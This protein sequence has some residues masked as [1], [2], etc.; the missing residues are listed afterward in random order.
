MWA[1]P[2]PTCGLPCAQACPGAMSCKCFLSGSKGGT[3]PKGPTKS[4]T[5]L[6][7]IDEEEEVRRCRLYT[8]S[9]PR[10]R[11]A[12]LPAASAGAEFW[13]KWVSRAGASM[14]DASEA[15]TTPTALLEV[16]A[17]KSH[18]PMPQMRSRMLGKPS[19]SCLD[20]EEV[21]YEARP[22]SVDSIRG[23]TPWPDCWADSPASSASPRKRSPGKTHHNRLSTASTAA[24]SSCYSPRRQSRLSRLSTSS[25][26]SMAYDEPPEPAK[27]K[28]LKTS[29]PLPVGAH[30]WNWPR[31]CD[32]KK[33]RV[34]TFD[35]QD[36]AAQRDGFVDQLSKLSD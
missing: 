36:L 32:E 33:L 3:S 6:S 30:A 4:P 20:E 34:L 35:G 12:A 24:G 31:S 25:W 11:H 9:M 15:A 28:A 5:Q 16:S 17:P 13:R 22:R 14:A 26:T 2:L 21:L 10:L 19:L 1:V 23:S 29:F 18:G 8:A 27:G 7:M